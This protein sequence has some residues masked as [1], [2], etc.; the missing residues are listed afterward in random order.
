L[1][2]S[3]FYVL[4]ILSF[5]FQQ[6]FFSP[7]N[8]LIA[9]M[10]ECKVLK[11]LHRVASLYHHHHQHHRYHHHTHRHHRQQL[12]QQ[13]SLEIVSSKVRATLLL[14]V[15]IC[16]PYRT[17]ITIITTSSST[18]TIIIIKVRQPTLDRTQQIL[19]RPLVSIVVVMLV[20]M[21]L[22]VIKYCQRQ[23]AS[24][25]PLHSWILSRRQRLIW[26]STNLTIA[27]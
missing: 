8:C 4:F 6:I 26:P 5:S 3:F 27:F 16:L 14:Q 19:E 25:L 22:V 7:R 17:T 15:I 1:P 11:L 10:A 24:V 9:D 23:L 12:H 20:I 13:P 18:S 2:Y 21:S